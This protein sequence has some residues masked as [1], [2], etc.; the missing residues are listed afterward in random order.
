MDYNTNF[1]EK[2]L[3]LWINKEEAKALLP[4]WIRCLLFNL[5]L[6]LV[7]ANLQSHIGTWLWDFSLSSLHHKVKH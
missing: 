6:L 2:I 3:Q 4:P 7:I 1:K 5:R